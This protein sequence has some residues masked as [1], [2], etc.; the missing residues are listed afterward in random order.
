MQ[1]R[2]LAAHRAGRGGGAVGVGVQEVPGH[3]EPCADL[4]E[5]LLVLGLSGLLVGKLAGERGQAEHRS[6]VAGGGGLAE[7]VGCHG[8]LT[9]A[10]G[11]RSEQV[12]RVTTVTCPSSC[13]LMISGAHH[14]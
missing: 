10:Q 11:L 14:G 13:V 2:L 7:P 6:Q 9:P 1:L 8:Q 5:V 12:E 4:V 3:V